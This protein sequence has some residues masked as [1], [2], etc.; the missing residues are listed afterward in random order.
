MSILNYN[1]KT[2][3]W[4]PESKEE[5]L[6]KEDL[7]GNKPCELCW[8]DARDNGVYSFPLTDKVT[9]KRCGC[10]RMI[11]ITNMIGIIK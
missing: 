2:G 6:Q 11:G 9:L 8:E 7:E 10:G 3:K 4:E 1:S 5:V